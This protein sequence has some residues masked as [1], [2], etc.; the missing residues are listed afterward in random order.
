[1]LSQLYVIQWAVNIQDTDTGMSIVK[2]GEYAMN[3]S[4]TFEE[5]SLFS[6]PVLTNR[7]IGSDLYVIICTISILKPMKPRSLIFRSPFKRNIENLML[8]IAIC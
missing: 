7:N 8:R 2:H 6:V 4:S 5:N 1:M 3:T